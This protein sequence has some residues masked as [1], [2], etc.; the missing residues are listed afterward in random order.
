MGASLQQFNYA[1]E[2]EIRWIHDLVARRKIDV[3]ENLLE[4]VHKRRWDPGVDVAAVRATLRLA[5]RI[6][7]GMDEHSRSK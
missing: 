3:L 6:Y 1:T 4:M 2:H 5:G 7:G